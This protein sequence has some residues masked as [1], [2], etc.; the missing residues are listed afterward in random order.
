MDPDGNPVQAQVDAYN[1][2][3]IDAF[4]AAYA[5]DVVITDAAGRAI[6]QGGDVIREEYGAMFEAS[7]DLRAEILGRI[8]TGEWTV[9]QERVSRGD[10]VR[11]LLVAYRV[12]DGLIARVVM[13]A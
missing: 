1:A 8:S 13:L 3:D 4:V 2:H 6:M 7:P 10:E 9:D 5:D 11:E 12:V